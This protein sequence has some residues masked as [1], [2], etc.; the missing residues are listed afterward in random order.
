MND[1]GWQIGPVSS[2]EPAGFARRH[3]KPS[4]CDISEEQSGI[5]WRNRSGGQ[6]NWVL[7]S[8]GFSGGTFAGLIGLL[9]DN[10][11]EH[12]ARKSG[13]VKAVY[14]MGTYLPG[15]ICR[16]RSVRQRFPTL[17]RYGACYHNDTVIVPVSS[18]VQISGSFRILN[19]NHMG[20]GRRE[21]FTSKRAFWQLAILTQSAVWDGYVVWW[22]W[23]YQLQRRVM[24]H[25]SLK[26]WP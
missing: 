12:L 10:F 2:C 24:S 9:L 15:L 17:Y 14:G 20:A 4:A 11:L 23:R 3:R 25:D 21:R 22:S 16:A 1:D 6:V 7:Q 19:V 18:V 26:A 13:V 5:M 8:T